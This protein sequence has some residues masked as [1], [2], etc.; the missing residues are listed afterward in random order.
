[1]AGVELR[2]YRI[3]GGFGWIC[4]AEAMANGGTPITEST[5][6]TILDEKLAP[7][8][9]RLG[10]IDERLNGIDER[11]GGIDERLGGIDERLN[12]IDER[13]DGI[14]ERLDGID[15]RLD[16]HG[17]LLDSNQRNMATVLALLRQMASKRP[18]GGSTPSVVPIAAQGN[19][20]G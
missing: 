4:Y 19:E 5:L 11:L 9:E 10:G 14:D 20:S 3:S 8:D 1:M 6:R 12:G 13:L 17:Q 7:I 15:E 18:R 16:I 2:H